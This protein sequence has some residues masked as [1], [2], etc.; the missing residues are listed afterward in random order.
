[1]RDGVMIAYL[2]INGEWCRQELPHMTLVY[3]GT[4]NEFR[5]EDFNALVKDAISVGRI[6]QYMSMRVINVDTFGDLE[7]RVDVLLLHPTPQLLIARK[8]VEKWDVSK[9]PFIPH[10]TIG[11]EGSAFESILPSDIYFNK[12]IVTY[13]SRTLT[14]DLDK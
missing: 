4:T 9:H 6:T 7:Q 3:C 2:P 11:P 8:L 14:F 12:L 1:M 5:Y 10:A 13:G